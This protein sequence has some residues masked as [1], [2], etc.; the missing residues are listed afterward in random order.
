ME[1]LIKE[2]YLLYRAHERRDG[3]SFWRSLCR[4]VRHSRDD[5]AKDKAAAETLYRN[6][7]GKDLE[8]A[9]PADTRAKLF[10]TLVLSDVSIRS[11]AF[12]RFVE[13]TMAQ[14]NSKVRFC[15]RL[16]RFKEL[17]DVQYWLGSDEAS[18]D[19]NRRIYDR[20]NIVCPYEING[21]E[22]TV[23]RNARMP[24]LAEERL[25][26]E[27]DT[28]VYRVKVD[29]FYFRG[30]ISADWIVRKDVPGHSS[31]EEDID[32]RLRRQMTTHA[33]IRKPY[34]FVKWPDKTSIFMK[35][36]S[37]TLLD[38]MKSDQLPSTALG[39][40]VRW[41]EKILGIAEALKYLHHGVQGRDRDA[42]NE[43]IRHGDIKPSNIMQEKDDDNNTIFK[44]YDFG[45][46]SVGWTSPGG[47]PVDQLDGAPP[48]FLPALLPRQ[49]RTIKGDVWSFGCLCLLCLVFVC[50]GMGD[51]NDVNGVKAFDEARKN[52]PV[53]SADDNPNQK[54]FVIEEDTARNEG[55]CPHMN[56]G[57]MRHHRDFYTCRET[58]DGEIPLVIRLSPGVV[59]YFDRICGEHDDR[60]KR[61]KRF[62]SKVFEILKKFALVPNPL[63]RGTME[64]LINELRPTI[65]EFSSRD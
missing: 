6:M 28:E 56:V 41:F 9:E 13:H 65:S 15:D 16:L 48:E 34:G 59:A 45:I 44:L 1:Q 3:T 29:P 26:P 58:D 35:L 27:R 22:R 63:Q 47:S 43:P 40:K 49:N 11:Q 60:P 52:D 23:P 53:A 36:A 17:A 2:L 20:Q 19:M 32:R 4:A 24:Y 14:G 42:P 31:N 50:D 62:V 39:G 8:R 37:C 21:D 30:S 57:K 55:D 64:D 18:A 46:S 7:V 25:T 38:L 10:A 54:F 33:H 61:E 12:R 51:D 5:V